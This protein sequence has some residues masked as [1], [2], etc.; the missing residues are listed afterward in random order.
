MVDD[1]PRRVSKVGVPGVQGI[2][3]R[4]SFLVLGLS[5]SPMPLPLQRI[6]EEIF[7]LTRTLSWIS[8]C[9]SLSLCRHEDRRL[10]GGKG[11]D[12]RWG[13][14][15]NGSEVGYNRRGKSGSQCLYFSAKCG[16]RMW[17]AADAAL[18]RSLK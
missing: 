10:Q 3:E 5:S 4:S 8:R 2:A 6:L 15:S 11:A 16:G 18:I 1:F 17:K 9:I 13:L 14:C 7:L 12:L